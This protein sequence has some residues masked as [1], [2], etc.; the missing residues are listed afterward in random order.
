MPDSK[1]CDGETMAQIMRP[2]RLAAIEPSKLARRAE[3]RL[4][5]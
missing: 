5:T 3:S 4:K 2:Q 1:T